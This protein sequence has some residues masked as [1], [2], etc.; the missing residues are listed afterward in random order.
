MH[1]NKH[2]SYFRNCAGVKICGWSMPDSKKSL[3]PVRRISAFALIAARKIGLSAASRTRDSESF[4]FVGICT[5]SI[6]R[7]AIDKKR[8]KASMRFGNF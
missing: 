3:S 4:S 2:A 8:F 7:S 6:D 5:I 1:T